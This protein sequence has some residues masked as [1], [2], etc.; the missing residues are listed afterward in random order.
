MRRQ[1]NVFSVHLIWRSLKT[2]KC[3]SPCNV[4]LDVH[5]AYHTPPSLVPPTVTFAART[6]HAVYT[7]VNH[8]HSI[9]K[10]EV[11]LGELLPENC[12]LVNQTPAWCFENHDTL[13]HFMCRV[14]PYFS[15]ITIWTSLVFADQHHTVT[16][17]S[18]SSA[19]YWIGIKKTIPL[20]FVHSSLLNIL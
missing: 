1:V 4:D 8:F 12:C 5:S 17:L 15:C 18:G 9:N 19:S 6:R 3:Q 16:I 7:S 11:A 20:D 13:D 14:N 10:K 2:L